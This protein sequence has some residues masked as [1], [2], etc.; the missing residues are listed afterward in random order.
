[1]WSL[2]HPWW[3]YIF[4]AVVVYAYVFALLRIV[5]KKQV[6]ELGPFD[7]V[8]LLILSEAVST[9]LTGGDNSLTAG[10]ISVT[11]FVVMN[12]LVDYTTF[13]S[14]KIEKVLDGQALVIIKEGKIN[15]Q[16]RQKE[17]VTY[18]EIRSAMREHGVS[19]L[20]EVKFAML[21]TNGQISIIENNKEAQP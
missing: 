10:L 17:K 18:E 7:L 19:Q 14:K 1:M 8:L 15:E 4:R 5:G 3:E 16:V 13:K 6:G 12:Y 2:I 11:T 9:A 21:E 20:S